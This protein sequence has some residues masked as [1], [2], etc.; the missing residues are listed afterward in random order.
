MSILDNA[1]AAPHVWNLVAKQ[2]REVFPLQQGE[3]IVPV[4]EYEVERAVLADLALNFAKRFNED[5]GFD[6]VR[7]LD[8]C[9]PD[10]D[11]FPLSELWEG[12][13]LG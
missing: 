10:T 12:D 8:T 1:Y 7:W 9:S 5:K 4:D 3:P 6:P 13:Q 11:R 2:I